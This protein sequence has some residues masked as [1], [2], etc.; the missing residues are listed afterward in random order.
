MRLALFTAAAVALIACVV[1]ATAM[2]AVTPVR[3]VALGDSY[4]SGEGNEPFDGP[5][6]RALG[7]DSAYP[8]MLP[9]MVDYLP[10]PFFRACTG[11]TIADVSQRP[12]PRRGSQ[13]V[14]LEYVNSSTD[15]VTLTIGGNDLGFA[16]IVVRCLLPG[17]CS[18]GDFA[19]RIEAGFAPIRP[20]LA[21]TYR[22]VRA[23]MDPDGYLVVGGYP[24]LFR[25]GPKSDCKSFISSREAAWIDS[26][27]DR[28]NALIATATRDARYSSG[29][30]AYVNVA[31]H[32]TGHELCSDDPW[33]YGI[34]VALEGGLIKGS[35]H[36]T[37]SGQRA[38]AAAF[39]AFLQRP[40]IR[41]ALTG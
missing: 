2:A 22:R 24:R 19:A 23:R 9:G 29:N 17:D 12:Q 37:K 14:Q 7:A 38:F 13:D 36:P 39:A 10:T 20:R 3:Y 21:D 27:V 15:L 32:V 16:S 18:H 33:L 40:T 1:P 5:C 26:L 4:S 6:H 35:Y 34:K 30:V 8:R 25:L 11:A 28:G 31:S 41:A